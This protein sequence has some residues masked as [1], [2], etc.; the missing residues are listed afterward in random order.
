MSAYAY[1]ERQMMLDDNL[2]GAGQWEEEALTQALIDQARSQLH[3]LREEI[4]SIE[5]QRDQFGI[6]AA[7][8]YQLDNMLASI[9]DQIV[10]INE[11]W[12]ELE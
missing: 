5:Q 6:G 11:A 2:I 1:D 9:N 4:K 7:A 8:R 10:A 12:G 3:E